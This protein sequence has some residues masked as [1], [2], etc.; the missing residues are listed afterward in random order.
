M[1][2]LKDK[3][4]YVELYYMCDL[5]VNDEDAVIKQTLVN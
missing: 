3:R 2:E 1:A 4:L 5:P